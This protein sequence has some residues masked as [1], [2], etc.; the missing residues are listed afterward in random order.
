MLSN[1]FFIEINMPQYKAEGV[2]EKGNSTVLFEF[3]P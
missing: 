3:S 2:S 1:I